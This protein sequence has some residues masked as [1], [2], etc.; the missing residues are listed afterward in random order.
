MKS[1]HRFFM[2]LLIPAALLFFVACAQNTPEAMFNRA[3]EAYDSGDM[4]G[5]SL[6]FDEFV[7]QHPDHEYTVQA[8]F[9]LA[10]SYM[11][12]RDFMS[13]RRV[14]QEI[15]QRFSQ[16]ANLVTRASF[17]IGQTHIQEGNFE[18]AAAVYESVVEAVTEPQAIA[19]AYS[20]LADVYTRSQD[21]PKAREYMDKIYTL[22]EDEIENPTESLQL[23]MY[24]L[25]GKARIAMVSEE[26]EMARDL[27]MDSFDLIEEAT[28]VSGLQEAKQN[29]LLNW[30]H[31]YVRANDFVQAASTYEQLMENPNIQD[32]QK[33]QLI[34]WKI[35]S[36]ER[37]F[38][39]DN[40][41][42]EEERAQLVEEHRR[43]I[44]NYDETDYGINARVQIASLI[45]DATPEEAQELVETAVER[46]RQY[47]AEP[48]NQQRPMIAMFQIAQAYMAIQDW[49]QAEESLVQVQNTYGDIPRVNQQVEAM[50]QF[51]EEQ[52][53]PAAAGDIEGATEELPMDMAPMPE[54]ENPV[55]P[56]LLEP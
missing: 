39:E 13:A 7:T 42:S 43:F 35:Q 9:M 19:G 15:Q 30:A 14:Y 40:D 55:E 5:A 49:D 46:L 20:Q 25:N 52:R 4:V 27:Y 21:N 53:N 36:M 33:P 24:S 45:K 34:V 44:E 29:A 37:N 10:D 22:A 56:E 17:E 32:E 6:Y 12:L 26:F 18:Q 41:L 31:T 23:K 8:Y 11:N 1:D 51:I 48:P 38:T 2:M 47:I 3:L 16:E 54:A 28:G 50:L